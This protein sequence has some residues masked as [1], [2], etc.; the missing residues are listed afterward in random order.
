MT[1]A[2]NSAV[3][4][5]ALKPCPNPWCASHDKSDPE[6]FAAHRPIVMPNRHSSGW[7][8]ACPVCPLQIPYKASEAEA[9]DTWN[10]RASMPA[11]SEGDWSEAWSGPCTVGNMIANLRTLPPETP[12]YSAYHISRKDAPSLLR[13][14]RPTLSRERVDGI[15]IKT[16]D[17]RV[18]YSAVIWSHPKE[19]DPAPSDQE[20]LVEELVEALGASIE[21]LAMCEPR[22]Q[23]GAKC[24][25]DAILNGHGLI[26]RARQS[27]ETS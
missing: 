26:T 14:R 24:Q 19:P 27:G 17:E 12:L 9:V 3:E 22:T 13:V 8:V 4:A 5:V 18:P 7:S 10:D 11:A 1:D 21:A 23:H 20:K 15:T 2:T 6:L 25:N 16:G